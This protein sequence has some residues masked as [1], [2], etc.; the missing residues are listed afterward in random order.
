MDASRD[1]SQP[2]PART[3][4]PI[5][6]GMSATALFQTH[7]RGATA[8]RLS[9]AARRLAE[10]LL[11][12]P[13]LTVG[14]SVDA[15]L[16][17]T[18]LAVTALVPLMRHGHIDWLIVTGTNL[19]YDALLAL[20]KPVL[21]PHPSETEFLSAARRFSPDDR[22]ATEKTL[23][24]LLAGPDFQK[25]MG[26]A[27]LHDRIGR[28]LRHREKDLGVDYPGLLSTAH[29]LGIPIINPS[30]AEGPLGSII[31]ELAQVGNRL[32]IDASLDLNLAAG[33]LNAA[34][35]EG[36]R[37]ACAFWC[38]GAGVGANLM[39]GSPAH[40]QRIV[41]REG[42]GS[43]PFRLR[44]AG[45]AHMHPADGIDPINPDA[46]WP[47]SPETGRPGGP[48]ADGRMDAPGDGP[49]DRAVGAL[50]DRPSGTAAGTPGE[51]SDA[52]TAPGKGPGATTGTPPG[53]ESAPTGDRA[54]PAGERPPL[55]SPR[56]IALATDL[57]M[58]LPL[59]TA[60]LLDRVPP[61][62]PKRLGRRRD[63]LLDG[64][65]QAQLN[66]TLRRPSP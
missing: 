3:V 42:L 17:A 14:L 27:E 2:D 13:E 38:L 50:A 48:P 5:E 35:V 11:D 57:S 10:E 18:G 64:L 1:R 55:G 39:L 45:H 12:Q 23:R 33:I 63:D 25:A 47:P 46:L 36:G 56:D 29:E 26:S 34:A 66:S 22:A 30:P 43:R 59:L 51:R 9:L 53:H 20:R 31:A 37:P 58:A 24:E 41:G 16:T 54:T 21:P 8:G 4:R 6:I 61:R 40:L 62:P 65:R 7:F 32:S 15:P 49:S 60:F 28:E 52:D 44:M 19:Y